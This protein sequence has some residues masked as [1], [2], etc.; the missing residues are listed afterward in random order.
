MWYEIKV[1]QVFTNY[2]ISLTAN[3]GE[4]QYKANKITL[5][6]KNDTSFS[7]NT[8][9][10]QSNKYK[11]EENI[12]FHLNLVSQL[13]ALVGEAGIPRN[14]DKR[15]QPYMAIYVYQLTWHAYVWSRISQ[16][17]LEIFQQYFVSC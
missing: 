12:S 10:A 16:K 3:V 17:R 11:I 9:P 13:D 5:I 6:L 4:W 8:F 14:F 2:A 1:K 7:H 15:K